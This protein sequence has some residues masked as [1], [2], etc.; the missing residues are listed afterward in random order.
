M[1]VGRADALL[2]L[3]L[4]IVAGFVG[5]MDRTPCRPGTIIGLQTPACLLVLS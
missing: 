2:R 5:V 3:S 1:T 4:D